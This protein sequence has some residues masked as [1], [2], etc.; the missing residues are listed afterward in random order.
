[1]EDSLVEKEEENVTFNGTHYI[2]FLSS[3]DLHTK[4][5]KILKEKI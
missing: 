3:S 1:M 5:R 2:V 4:F